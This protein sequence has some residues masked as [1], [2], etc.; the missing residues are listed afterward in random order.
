[1]PL[2]PARIRKDLWLQL[3]LKCSRLRSLSGLSETV[4]TTASGVLG[5]SDFLAESIC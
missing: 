2:S 4:L 3:T 5:A 1:M